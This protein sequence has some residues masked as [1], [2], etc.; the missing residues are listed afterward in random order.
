MTVFVI[1]VVLVVVAVLAVY[2]ASVA[3]RVRLYKSSTAASRQ[4]VIIELERRYAQ[5]EPF[6][7][8]AESSGLNGESVRQLVGARSWSK[9]VRERGLELPTQ[10]AAENALSAAVH[11]VFSE[12]DSHPTVKSTWAF[13]GPA[14]DLA[15]TEKRIT[16]AVRVYNDNADKLAS[17]RNSYPTKPV[18]KA[19]KVTT[20][21]LFVEHVSLVADAPPQDVPA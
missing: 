11:E 13:Q 2:V 10:A 16:G 17:L 19:M 5:L 12:S 8:A 4:L 20:P 3:Q 9:A 7:A 18:A 14:G 15:V 6:I 21:D 1:G